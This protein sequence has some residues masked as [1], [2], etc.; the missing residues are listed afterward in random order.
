[1]IM[2]KGA[3]TYA[4]VSSEEQVDGYS[5]DVQVRECRE[6][7]KRLGCEVM[8][9]FVEQGVSGAKENRPALAA[10]LSFCEK[11]KGKVAYV[12]VKDVDRFSRD[13]L[14]HQILKGKLKA[15][16]VT[17]YSINQPSIAE[18]SPHAR[19]MENIFSSVAQLEREQ[20]NSRCSMGTLE[21]VKEGAWT[22]PAPYGYE[23]C[24][25]DEGKSTLK[26]QPERAKAVVKA[27][28]MY[29]QGA[30]LIHIAEKLHA[31]GYRTTKGGRFS[32][33]TMFHWLHN[34][35]YIGKVSNK[36]YPDRLIDGL[37]PSLI[38]IDLWNRV[39]QRFAGRSVVPARLKANP[40]FALTNILRCHACNAPICGSYS[41]SRN[42]NRYA[43]Y[44]CRKPGCKSKNIQRDTSEKEFVKVL[45]KI[46]PTD[47]CIRIFEED[48]IKVQREKWQQHITEKAKLTQQLADL[49]RRRNAIEDKYFSGS[50]DEETYQRNKKRV[51]DDILN[52]TKARD[53]H[54]ISEEKIRA[55][56]EFA[57]SFITSISNT[58]EK[59]LPDDKRLVQKLVFPIGLRLE[60]DGKYRTLQLPPLL[61]I[62]PK[63]KTDR[64]KMVGDPGFEPGTFRM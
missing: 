5:L 3:V 29:D 49:E 14:V 42:G 32:K 34:P 53:E 23:L 45:R 26:P 30:L 11:N 27:F 10:L 28:E 64:S 16:G 55:L 44:H 33:Q 41:R 4:R 39:Q 54:V 62:I 61:A 12:I 15:L 1:M 22:S 47:E 35:A 8:D 51:E 56:L 60:K 63:A 57:R 50:I 18:D 40:E 7:A 37:H 59:S 43:Y 24:R 19:F 58:W 20:I 13:T 6:C 2:D 38:P 52:V 21:A 25:N 46:R 9:E 48:V 36:L 17:L 31:L